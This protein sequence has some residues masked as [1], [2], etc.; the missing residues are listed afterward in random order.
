[1]LH[2]TLIDRFLVLGLGHNSVLFVLC[3]SC[4][5]TR[6]TLNTSTRVSDDLYQISRLGEFFRV[7]YK[8]SL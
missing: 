4:L 5:H 1:M 3:N 2:L 6:T 8:K 7:S